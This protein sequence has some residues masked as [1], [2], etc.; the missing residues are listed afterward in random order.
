MPRFS[1]KHLLL[2]TTLAAAALVAVIWLVDNSQVAICDGRF[3]LQVDLLEDPKRPIDEIAYDVLG[4]TDYAKYLKE[5]PNRLEPE[6]NPTHVDWVAGQPF[7]VQVPCSSRISSFGRELS[8]S[9]FKLLVL[10]ITHK[11]HSTDWI[12]VAIPELRT[13]RQ[14]EISAANG[15]M[16]SEHP[17]VRESQ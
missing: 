14:I 15:S 4:R 5:S 12:P 3:P 16:S 6:L 9:Q 10:R 8:Y 11:D 13:N 7:T 17:T 2:A 1:V